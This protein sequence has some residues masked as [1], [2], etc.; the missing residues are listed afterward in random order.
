MIIFKNTLL[1]ISFILASLLLLPLQST[2]EDI[3]LV[4]D[5][6]CPYSC[7]PVEDEADGFMVEIA[8]EIFKQ[9]GIDVHYSIMPWSRAI[10]MTREGVESGI[11]GAIEDEMPGM[12]FPDNEQAMSTMILLGKKGIP[13]RYTGMDSLRK[14]RIAVVKDYSYGKEMDAYIKENR[15]TKRVVVSM[16]DS[17]LA[18][19]LK[20]LEYD[21]V[22]VIAVDRDA[23]R[24][25]AHNKALGG[26]YVELGDIDV[27]PLYIAFSPNNPKSAYY[28]KL[29]SDGMSKL[30]ASGKLAEILAG[31]GLKDWK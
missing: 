26:E 7:N 22:D 18:M 20:M 9:A 12:I 14:L 8:Q 16:G 3:S 28:R 31:Y 29:L 17:P 27:A 21:R 10:R 4:A 6:W 19:N 25:Y 2:A 23:Y 1:S 13:W 15:D 5:A 11:V 24:Y 30:R